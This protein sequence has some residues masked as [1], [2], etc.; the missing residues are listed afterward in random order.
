MREDTIAA[1]NEQ[2][3]TLRRG[4]TAAYDRGD[5]RRALD[6]SRLLDAIQAALWKR[7]IAAVKR[8]KS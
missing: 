5:L 4:L 7:T 8:P 2:T 6:I 1:I 3:A